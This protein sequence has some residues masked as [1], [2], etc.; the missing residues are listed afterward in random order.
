VEEEGVEGLLVATGQ[1]SE[2]VGQKVNV[3]QL[4][5]HRLRMARHFDVAVSTHGITGVL[6]DDFDCTSP[7]DKGS[8]Q[9]LVGQVGCDL[10]D[11]TLRGH[12]YCPLGRVGR[13][14]AWAA[15]GVVHLDHRILVAKAGGFAHGIDVR[16]AGEGIHSRV[17]PSELD[18][19][20]S[21]PSS[22]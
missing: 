19:M 2:L 6:A 10:K 14:G 3:L 1:P 9:L 5:L 21:L 22:N 20:S 12:G 7:V 17:F 8:V 16:A 13:A 11:Q 15:P 18:T 4:A